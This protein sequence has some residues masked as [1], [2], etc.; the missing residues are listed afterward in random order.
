MAHSVKIGGRLPQIASALLGLCALAF[1]ASAQQQGGDLS[2]ELIDPHVLRVCSDPGNLPFSND[3]GEGFENKIAELLAAKLGKTVAYT[4]FPQVTGFVRNTLG[5]HRCDVVMGFAQGDELVQNTNPYYRTTYALIYKPGSG[6]DGIDTLSDPRLK[7]KR[8]G[9]VAQTPPA[10][11]LLA[12]GL[13]QGA[14]AYPLLVDTRLDSSGRDMARDV[15]SGEIAA[16]VLWGPMAGYFAKNTQPALA[17]VPL[18][19]EV[20]G[21]RQSFYITM[22]VRASDQEWKR[23]LNRLLRDNKADIDKILLDYGVPLLDDQNKPVAAP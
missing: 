7:G 11:L 5:A 18:L 12:N 15:A 10:D 8:V 1:P 6:L 9:V 23:S 13:L 21:P 2:L 22:G 20:G 19:K 3:K 14:K 17:V 16:G 4:W